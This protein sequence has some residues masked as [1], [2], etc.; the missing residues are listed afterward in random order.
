MAKK[1]R[2]P[3]YPAVDLKSA[4]SLVRKIYPAA[5]HPLGGDV[6]AT[7]WD[8]KGQASASPYLAA[9]KQYG[10]LTEEKSGED[11]LFKLTSVA[12]DIAVDPECSSKECHDALKIAALSPKI[13]K[14][15]WDKWGHPLPP[16]GEIRRYLER[17]RDFNPNYVSRFIKG[18]KASLEYAQITKAGRDGQAADLDTEKNG[19]GEN[20]Q[21]DVRVGS[22]VQWTSDGRE[23]FPKPLKVAGVSD[24]GEWAF[25]EGI[26]TGLA[27]SELTVETPPT[28]MEHKA[29]P[30]N[31]FFKQSHELPVDGVA[32][33]RV[34]LDEGP[35]KLEWP[36]EL[37]KE[38]VEE[39]EYWLT[40]IIKRAKRKAGI[41]QKRTK[42][43]P[44]D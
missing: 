19:N 29:P 10:L 31:P 3:A 2:S 15:L 13:H 35:V 39:L 27:M 12:L 1:H 24:D 34:T 4:V 43:G 6:I 37:S 21:P 40:G 20:P 25:V 32:L 42:P 14:E 16:D 11:R 9:L 22:Y 23:Q 36:K 41:E 18:Y 5:K 26:P 44:P 8:Y 30:A 28:A 33:E 38:S 7:E 17:E